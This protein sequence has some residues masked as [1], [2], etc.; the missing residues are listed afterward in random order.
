MQCVRTQD[1][2]KG[3]KKNQKA[4]TFSKGICISPNVSLGVS[5]AVSNSSAENSTEIF[6]RCLKSCSNNNNLK[7]LNTKHAQQTQWKPK[8]NH[9]LEAHIKKI[10]YWSQFPHGPEV[11]TRQLSRRGRFY[12]RRHDLAA[13]LGLRRRRRRRL[14]PASLPLGSLRPRRLRRRVQSCSRANGTGA[15]GAVS[16]GGGRSSICLLYTSPSP[17]D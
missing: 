16:G 11:V 10:E 1:K 6:K 14:L 12:Q 9:S 17:R 2:T 8:K 3:E 5:K 15:R 13:L 4:P 7:N